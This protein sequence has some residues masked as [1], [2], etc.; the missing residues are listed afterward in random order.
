V[1]RHKQLWEKVA[2]PDNLMEAAQDALRGKRGKR[3]GAA[4]FQIWEKEVVRLARELEDGDLF[5]VVERR[6]GLPIG[7]L[8]SQFFANIYLDAFDHFVK[9]ELRVKGYVRYVDDFL[10]YGEDRATLKPLGVRCSAFLAAEHLEIHPDKYRL[11]PTA[12]GAAMRSRVTPGWS[13]MMAL[14]RPARRL[15]SADF[16]AFGRPTMAT[17]GMKRIKRWKPSMRKSGGMRSFEGKLHLDKWAGKL[18][19]I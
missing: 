19:I 15:K 8:T 4:F 18:R 5:D 12:D 3:A 7:N 17:V 9:Q 10:L 2:S 1:K 16:P 13:C 14:F 11:I 6:K